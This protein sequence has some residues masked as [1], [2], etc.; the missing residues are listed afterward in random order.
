MKYTLRNMLLPVIFVLA[1]MGVST[2]V[3]AASSVAK[4]NISVLGTEVSPHKK[5]TLYLGTKDKDTGK[6]E[7]STENIKSRMHEICMK[8][9]D[10]YTVSV[11]DGYYRDEKGNPVH[12][13]SLVYFFL[14]TPIDALGHI[15][16]EAIL[17]FNQNSILLEESEARSIFYE[18]AHTAK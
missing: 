15:M 8:Y 12:E 1:L 2:T 9:V 10:G 5:Y 7:I 14:D 17:E 16:D 18:G 13:V 4:E 3:L 11:M 6:Q